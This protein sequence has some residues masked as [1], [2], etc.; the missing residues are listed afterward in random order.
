MTPLR[1]PCDVLGIGANSIDY[2]TVAPAFPRPEGWFSKMQIR[3]HLVTCGGQTAT[4]MAVCAKFGLR[5]RYV[6]AVG[7]DENG[8]RVL[9]DLPRHQVDASGVVTRDGRNQFAVI[10]IDGETGERAVLWDRDPSLA[11]TEDDVPLGD[12]AAARVLHVDDVDQA[13]AIRAARHAAALGIPVT[14][15]LDRMT[16]RTADLVDAVTYP[17][18]AD[19]LHEKLTGCADHEEALRRLCRPHHRALCVTIGQHGAVA[20]AGGRFIRSPG[21]KVE[22]VDTTG[23]GD[24]FRGAFIHALLQGWDIERILC[25]AN[26]AAALACT[27]LGAMAGIPDLEA[28]LALAASRSSF[29]QPGSPEA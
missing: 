28:S 1:D 2:V 21:F 27:G 10:V 11:L 4:A 24:V 17:I 9:A 7:A 13:A 6:G 18:F 8:Q 14:S 19:G 5:A 23:S 3:R 29:V 25:F 22:A 12:I 15:D 16:D 20:L 26:A